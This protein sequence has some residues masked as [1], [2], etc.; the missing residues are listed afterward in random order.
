MDF[1]CRSIAIA[2]LVRSGRTWA[3]P[4]RSQRSGGK[5]VGALVEGMARVP[6]EPMPGHLVHLS[7]ANQ[8]APQVLIL[9]RFFVA[10]T[11]AAAHPSVYPL[12]NTLL[13]VCGVG[14]QVHL[15]RTEESLQER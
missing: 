2:S 13:H 11:P 14:V 7:Q 9:D 15:T 5:P 12:C 8:Y 1:H 4:E 6:P 3:A 10:G